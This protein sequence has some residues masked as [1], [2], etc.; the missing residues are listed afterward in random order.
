MRRRGAPRPAD[1][2]WHSVEHSSVHLLPH[3]GDEFLRVNRGFDCEDF[4]HNPSEVIDRN[5]VQL[6][7]PWNIEFRH[8]IGHRQAIA[9]NIFDRTHR[10]PFN[11]ELGIDPQF[12]ARGW[13]L[14]DRFDCGQ[15]L[16]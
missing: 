8:L 5:F 2:V 9:A 3:P 14:R 11:G 12:A 16:P 1:C 4:H 10:I 15:S 6:K 13:I 7:M